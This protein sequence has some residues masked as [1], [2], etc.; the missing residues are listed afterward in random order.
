VINR[1]NDASDAAIV[2]SPTGGLFTDENGGQAEFTVELTVPPTSDVTVQLFSSNTKEGTVSASSVR[3]SPDDWAP[4][5]VFV[6]GVND[7]VTDGNRDYTIITAWATSLDRRYHGINPADVRV[8]NLDNDVV[9]LPAIAVTAGI[10]LNT[11]EAGH[12]TEFSVVLTA[13]PTGDVTIS[14]NTSDRTEGTPSLDQ[15]VFTPAN[16][17]VPQIVRVIGADDQ[18]DDDDVT[19]RIITGW[20]VSNDSRYHGLNPDDVVITN[21]DDGDTFDR[22]DVT[23]DGFVSPID[24]L[25]VI[26][27][28]NRAANTAVA[29]VAADAVLDL[30]VSND[31]FVSPLDAL[32]VINRLNEQAH[33]RQV[34]AVAALSATLEADGVE[35]EIMEIAMDVH[36]WPVRRPIG[37]Y[38]LGEAEPNDT[39]LRDSLFS[40]D[41]LEASEADGEWTDRTWREDSAENEDLLFGWLRHSGR[42]ALGKRR[43][44]RV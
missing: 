1:D 35:S 14:L 16:W 37:P 2:I 10:E 40:L 9:A 24:A 21:Q 7:D 43:G 38:R 29:A 19:Y 32:L 4:R 42:S 30:D 41:E 31:G 3:F 8:S 13:P 33:S 15:L 27:E 22:L 6:T 44:K 11:T 5:K 12:Q 36:R 34:A 28:L 18:A 26:N 25:M 20:L 23:L 39:D 17:N